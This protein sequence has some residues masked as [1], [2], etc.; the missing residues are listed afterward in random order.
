MYFGFKQVHAVS[1]LNLYSM[2]VYGIVLCSRSEI[3]VSTFTTTTVRN[4]KI[5]GVCLGINFA[6]LQ[7]R[8]QYTCI[9]RLTMFK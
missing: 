6:E 2:Y 4:K 1:K 3:S 7:L 9:K 5:T 8:L